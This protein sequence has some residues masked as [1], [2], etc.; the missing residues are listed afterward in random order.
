[1]T[2][3]LRFF[4]SRYFRSATVPTTTDYYFKEGAIIYTVLEVILAL[5]FLMGSILNSILVLVFFRR[6]GFRSHISNRYVNIGSTK[7]RKSQVL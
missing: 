3:N 4:L 7:A 5:V 1:M 2:F 6:R